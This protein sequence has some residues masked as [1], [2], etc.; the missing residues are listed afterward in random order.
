MLSSGLRMPIGEGMTGCGEEAWSSPVQ[1]AGKRRRSGPSE[2]DVTLDDLPQP[3]APPSPKHMVSPRR[4]SSGR[5][6]LGRQRTPGIYLLSGSTTC[7]DEA[8]SV[9]GNSVTR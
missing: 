1:T 4:R 2:D 5:G 6:R 8:L 3:A 9:S 7:G